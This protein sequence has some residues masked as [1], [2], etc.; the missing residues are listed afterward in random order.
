MDQTLSEGDTKGKA[1]RKSNRCSAKA[2]ASGS[3]LLS[4]EESAASDLSASTGASNSTR[5]NLPKWVEKQLAEDIEAAGGL[6]IFDKGKT[7]G[8][9]EL[10]DHRAIT[11][12]EPEVFGLR[13]SDLRLKVRSKVNRWKQWDDKKYFAKL[14][15]LGVK[16]A[17]ARKK[18]PK[19]ASSSDRTPS[20]KS[21]S[22]KSLVESPIPEVSS[23]EEEKADPPLKSISLKKAPRP[24]AVKA[25]KKEEGKPLPSSASVN[26]TSN[27]SS[28]SRTMSF[29]KGKRRPTSCKV[30]LTG[31]ASLASCVFLPLFLIAL[32]VSHVRSSLIPASRVIKGKASI[33]SASCQTTRKMALRMMGLC[34]SSM[35]SSVMLNR[36]TTGSIT[37]R[38][39]IRC[40]FSS[41][42]WQQRTWRTKTNMILVK[43]I[44][45]SSKDTML[46]AVLTAR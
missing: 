41:Q 28:R 16:P 38:E 29:K 5:S 36:E 15:Q 43:R 37:L 34:S 3:G 14:A 13:G 27:P 24:Q 32:Q 40:T 2:R 7:Q 18:T 19:K 8:L 21:P 12:E 26:P 22:R 30:I 31:A 39:P 1:Q 4:D 9:S 25:E 20:R 10:L 42:R 46:P 35:L 23:P 17:V 6:R 33:V 44:L 45:M 11:L